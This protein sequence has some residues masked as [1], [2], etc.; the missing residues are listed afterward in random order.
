MG[1]NG[2]RA[3]EDSGV[4]SLR[5]TGVRSMAV[6]SPSSPLLPSAAGGSYAYSSLFGVSSSPYQQLISFDDPTKGE[7]PAGLHIAYAIGR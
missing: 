4:G 7:V 1:R 5:V 6:P 2:R 3:G